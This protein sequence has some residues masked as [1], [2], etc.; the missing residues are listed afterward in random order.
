VNESFFESELCES[1]T[2]CCDCRLSRK[3]REGIALA[4]D[5]P[6]VDF[7]C[8]FHKTMVN[9]HQECLDSEGPSFGA[10]ALNFAS[11]MGKVVKQAAKGGRVTVSKESQDRRLAI[12]AKCPKFTEKKTC[13][14]CGCV[15]KFKTKLATD[16][17][18]EGRW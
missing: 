18:P 4:F 12:C 8:P 7:S 1:Q 9:M 15:L 5:V 3:Y 13:K 17:C 10:K 11:S 14:V 6:E 16:H 2:K